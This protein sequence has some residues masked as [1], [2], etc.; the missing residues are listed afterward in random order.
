MHSMHTLPLWAIVAAPPLTLTLTIV[1]PTPAM[2]KLEV[3]GA[4]PS[5]LS[6]LMFIAGA[7]LSLVTVIL[8]VAVFPSCVVIVAVIVLAPAV[9][10]TMA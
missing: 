8:R 5:A 2:L 9:N 4:I 7:I 10:G 6:T 1:A 3:K